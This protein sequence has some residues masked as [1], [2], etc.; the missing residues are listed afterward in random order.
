MPKAKNANYPNL[1]KYP[2]AINI[3]K[4]IKNFLGIK[5]MKFFFCGGSNT[6]YDEHTQV[7]MKT[8]NMYPDIVSKH[9]D[10]H[11]QV[12]DMYPDIVSKHYGA[13]YVNLGIVYGSNKRTIRKIFYEYNMEEYDL[14]CIDFTPKMR[15][16]F[17]NNED[18]RWERMG[19]NTYIPKF[20]KLSK[21]YYEN[22]Y[23]NEYG[24]LTSYIEFA[25]IKKY[26]RAIKKP[27]I[28]VNSQLVHNDDNVDLNLDFDL[29]FSD[30]DIKDHHL[31]QVGHNQVA[32]K[33]IKY[34][35]DFLQRG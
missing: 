22:F 9:Y 11:T 26:L 21:L 20:R 35:E 4:D 7:E 5:L 14:I 17:Y 25:T 2:R 10:E 23:N 29:K 27:H 8:S 15:T 24:L 30:Y 32:K 34:Y 19:I 28:I 13:T 33:I 3:S 18:K 1:Q 6:H 16:E 31:S 12:E